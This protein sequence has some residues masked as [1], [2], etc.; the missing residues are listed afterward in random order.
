MEC[1]GDNLF[2]LLT[3]ELIEVNC[4]TGNT[5]GEVRIIL[6]I[7]ICLDESFA[8]ENVDIDMMCLLCEV[9][10]KNC[11]KVCDSLV[12]RLSERIGSDGEGIGDTVAAVLL[13][14]V[15]IGVEGCERTVLFSVVHGVCAG[16]EGSAVSTAVGSSSGILTVH[17]V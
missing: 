14:K 12:L 5:D 10:V 13:A 1:S 4:I 6:G 15:C 8:V 16:G 11:N 17:Y 9:A 2:L 7:L 3:G